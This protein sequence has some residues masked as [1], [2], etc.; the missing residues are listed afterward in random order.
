MA[1]S[2][3]HK[4]GQIIGLMVESGAEPVL[5]AFA[6]E[7][8]LFLD[9]QGPREARSGLKVKWL[10]KYGNSHDLDF[11]LERGGTE[12][13][14]GEPVAFIESAWRRY[15][16]HSRNK[17]QEIQGAVRPLFDTHRLGSPFI[18]AI[19]A[20]EFTDGSVTQLRS[21]GFEVLHFPVETVKAAFASQDIDAAWEEDTS[22]DELESKIKDWGHL[23]P[24]QQ[25]AA[26]EALLELN[27]EQVDQFM[28][29][30]RDAVTRTVDAVRILPLHGSQC[31][32]ASIQDAVQFLS[33]FNENPSAEAFVRYEIRV[34]FS[35]GDMIEAQFA[36]KRDAI[37]FLE[38]VHPWVP[39]SSS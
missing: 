19:L 37:L 18:G 20:G 4:W 33:E 6:D 36:G 26:G 25:N 35:N 5:R 29:S 24:D 3:A 17:A 27:R 8:G 28:T 10:D 12:K 22:R 11:V 13:V 23:S 38:S 32:L 2:P 34:V 15:T 31:E 30:L 16:K 21:L 9:R 39:G 1:S 14:V 7:H